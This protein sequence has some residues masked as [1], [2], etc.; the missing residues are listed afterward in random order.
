[1]KATNK[2]ANKIISAF[3]ICNQ[4]SPRLVFGL[5]NIFLPPLKLLHLNYTIFFQ[6]CQQ[7]IIKF[8]KPSP[9][10]QNS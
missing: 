5:G 10:R 1:M 4:I 6:P 8:A 2:T 3:N 9:I 7:Y